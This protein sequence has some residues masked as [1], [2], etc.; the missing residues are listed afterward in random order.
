MYVFLNLFFFFFS[1]RRRHTRCGRDWS[2]DVCSSDLFTHCIP[3]FGLVLPVL[4]FDLQRWGFLVF[5]QKNLSLRRLLLS[6]RYPICPDRRCGSPPFQKPFHLLLRRQWLLWC[7]AP[8]GDSF[9]VCRP[10][11][12]CW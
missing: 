3:I 7:F 11:A 9:P 12:I 1:S 5:W 8:Q 6:Y 2:S 4:N 10:A